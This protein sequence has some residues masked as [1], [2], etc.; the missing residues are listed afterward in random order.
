MMKKDYYE[1]QK[2][3]EIRENR[4]KEQIASLQ[5]KLNDMDIVVK[6][7][8]IE[9]KYLQDRN[10]Y[11]AELVERINKYSNIPNIESVLSTSAIPHN[12][13]NSVFVKFLKLFKGK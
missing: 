5:S 12:K 11:L 1:L 7:Q 4:Y 9:I 6:K 3:F 13:S 8:N 2:V 10:R